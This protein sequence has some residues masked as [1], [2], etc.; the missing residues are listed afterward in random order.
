MVVKVEIPLYNGADPELIA[1][2]H[3]LK[4][5]QPSLAIDSQDIAAPL[6]TPL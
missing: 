2:K 4:A 5:R 3:H 6:L 1:A